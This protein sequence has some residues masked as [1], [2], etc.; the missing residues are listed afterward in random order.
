[1]I[2][3]DSILKQQKI[4][5]P[6]LSEDEFFEIY[7]ADNILLNY[8]LSTE[9]INDGIVD[10]PK[11]AGVDAAYVF[12]NRSLLTEDFEYE[13]IKQPVDI[14]LFIIQSEM[15]GAVVRMMGAVEDHFRAIAVAANQGHR[16]N[17]RFHVL[18]VLGWAL[19]E[20]VT[21]PAQRIRQLDLTKVTPALV[22]TV[23]DWVFSEFDS[24]GVTDRVAKE[25]TFTDRLKMGWNVAKTA[26]G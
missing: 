9:E 22:K 7:C 4:Q 11:D 18:M 25:T 13:G 3:L 17:L 14:E 16:N 15:Y 21:L 24:A 20:N 26:P 10:G 5:Y 23:T 1:M 2:L 8:D 12:V 6:E 19:N